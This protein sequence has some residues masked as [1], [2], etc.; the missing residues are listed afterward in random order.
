MNR[1]T[2]KIF[3]GKERSLKKQKNL[4]FSFGKNILTTV[5]K[6]AE[7]ERVHSDNRGSIL[8][9]FAICMPVFV[10][11]LFYINDLVR[12]KRWR[13]QTEFVAQQMANII[14]NIS[15]KR[16]NKKITANDIKYAV[17]TAYLSAFPGTSRFFNKKATNDLGYNPLGF[18]YCVQGISDSTAKVLWAKR[19]HISTGQIF[20]PSQVVVQNTNIRRSNVKNLTAGGSP[21]EIY[22][23]LRIEKDQIK[24][25]IECAIHYYPSDSYYFTDGRRTSN[26]SPAHAFGLRLYK[27]APPVTRDGV[28]NDAIYFHSAVIFTPNPELFNETAPV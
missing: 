13:S 21:S 17:S 18:I 15:Q 6:I 14:Q 23:L 20:N 10:I 5:C 16:S 2:E 7:K 26:V 28:A 4:A 8:I 24:I 22:P 11:L 27:L 3:E 19:F 1:V 9:E 12:L 25:I